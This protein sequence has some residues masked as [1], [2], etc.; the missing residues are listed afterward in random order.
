MKKIAHRLIFTIIPVVVCALLVVAMVASSIAKSSITDETGK[1]MEALM[2]A[3][4]DD[5]TSVLVKPETITQA[6]A[7]TVG[8]N[9]VAGSDLS[10]YGEVIKKYILNNECIV[11]IGFFMEPDRW[12]YDAASG[13]YK[14]MF[15][16]YWTEAED[17]VQFVD[18]G[19]NDSLTGTDWYDT[20]KKEGGVFYTETYVDTTLGILMTSYVV[21][22]YD[23]NGMFMG[24]VNTDIN[25][26]AVQEIVDSIYVGETGHCMLLTNDTGEFVAGAADEKTLNPDETVY[27]DEEIGLSKYSEQIMSADSFQAETVGTSG[28]NMIYS[29]R[30]K[31]YNWIL[32]AKISSS[33]INAPVSSIQTSIII[34]SIISIAVCAF[35]ILVVAKRISRSIINVKAM[36]EK[37]SEGD[38]TIENLEVKGRDELAA[39]AGALNSMLESNKVEMGAM[40]ESAS[41]ISE[42]SATLQ[43]AVAELE[44]SFAEISKAIEQI[45][46][47]MIDN[48]ATTEEL[49]A[50][51]S[52]VRNAVEN[53]AVKAKESESMA[54][55]IMDRAKGINK[56]STESFDRAMK[57]TK[58]YEL[59]LNESIENSKV[60]EEIEIMA[61]AIN[62]IASQI[63]L[64]SLNASIEAARAGEAGK[65]FAV[66]ASEIGKLAAQTSSTVASIQE[67]IGKVR[68]AV[69]TLSD[70]SG[71]IITFINENVNP[72]YQGFVDVSV[73]YE[74]DAVDIKALSEYVSSIADTLN[75]TMGE[76]NEAINNIANMSEN[77]TDR[78]SEVLGHVDVVAENVRNVDEISKGQNNVAGELN[79]VVSRYKF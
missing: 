50:S 20:L 60:V 55:E 59:E 48:N 61:E 28:K 33:E 18:I 39:M 68:A 65:G 15:N 38:Y 26:S 4:E 56:E 52:E 3:A 47:A 16:L 2:K 66:V 12:G 51:V 1:R 74:Q 27:T 42:N 9:Q 58:Q 73:K 41:T 36:A 37:M 13:S 11:A 25:M 17:G 14:N 7:D 19:Q 76:F 71:K 5:I 32:L 30:F 54:S 21:P 75:H 6:L 49:T 35:L 43:N 45:S 40:S 72:D 77:T 57:L 8:T 63:N 24:C 46:G 22:I 53:L 10:R 62:D 79:S 64:L 44:S 67:T 29:S 23:K 34:L 69:G 70:N 31:T 78:A